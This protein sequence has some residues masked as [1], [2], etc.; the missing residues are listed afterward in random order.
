MKIRTKLYLSLSLTIILFGIIFVVYGFIQRESFVGLFINEAHEKEVI[1]DKIL[2]LKGAPLETFTFDYSYW[3]EMVNFIANENESWAKEMINTSVLT[4]YGINAIW[5]YKTDY[6]L[7]YS[8]DNLKDNGFKEVPLNKEIINSVFLHKQLCHFFLNTSKGLMEIRGATIHPTLDVERKTPSR[9]YIFAA[10]LWGKEY[11]D[12]LSRLIGGTIQIT[13]PEEKTV[14]SNQSLEKA[15]I[16]FSRILTDWN[17]TPLI[18][19][20]IRFES[21]G[22]KEFNHIFKQRFIIF[23]LFAGSILVIILFIFTRWISMPL[24]KISFALN[25]KDPSY[26]ASLKRHNDEF[27]DILLMIENFLKQEEILRKSEEQFRLVVEE[28]VDYAIFMLDS[29]GRIVS[30]NKGAERIKGYR[31]GEIIGKHFSAFYTSE[32]IQRGKPE[33]ELKKARVEGRCEDEGW[34]VRK[35]G[36]QFLANAIITALY[37]QAGNLRG[38]SKVTRDIT[39]RKKS[40]DELYR[41][42]R[43]LKTISECNQTL[44]RATN[45]SNLLHEIC[46]NL[47]GVGGYRL[48]WVGF[49]EQNEKKIVRPVAQAGYE[50]GY[51]EN[52]NF[53]WSDAE[54]GHGPTGTSIRMG[55]ICICKNVLTDPRFAPW[56]DEAIKRG[57]ASSIAL[58]MTAE[59][60]T[61]G[62]LNIYADELDA[63]DEQ[64]VSMLEELTND[65]AYGIFALRTHSEREQ[66]QESL[67]KLH[68]AIEQTA[69]IVV[70]T[71]KEGVIEYVNPAFEKTTG[72]AKEI[73]IGQTP[74]II[75]SGK[76]DQRFYEMLWKTILSGN[77]FRDTLIN[78]RKN[79]EFY[80]A[81][82]AITPIIDKEGNITHFVSTDKDITERKEIE[83]T[84]RLAQL[85]EL[86][87]DMAH[88]VNN[89]LMII[90]GNAQLSLLDGTLN[91]EIK[92]N[93]KI[94][95]EEC[96]RAKDIIQRLL[97]FSRPSKGERK[98]TD[99][100]Q[101]I[102]SVTKL[103]EHQFSLS[104]VKIKKDLKYDLPA[105]VIDEKQ[106]QEV[107]MNLLNNARD[108][109]PEGGEIIINTS[110]DGE[111]CKIEMKDSG[112]G[113][114]DKTLARVFEPFFTT[115]EKGTGLGLS[116]CFGIIKAHNGKIEF[117]SQLQKGTTA[118]IWL[119]IKAEGV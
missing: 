4:N 1:F 3:D 66:A 52:L 38:F 45:E 104:N 112:V 90:S 46:R 116:V 106:M 53:T 61:F 70:I 119:P 114:D 16:T 108:A 18:R 35:D 59:G 2:I 13:N 8:I 48:A 7:L 110:L 101:S 25:S 79:G 14:V 47:V 36:S 26:I 75:K 111:Y 92:S 10:K 24:R 28:T 93:L 33:E 87:A 63:F 77:V 58:P 29:D 68:S 27:G 71:N 23:I 82:K 49:A 55:K 76:H 37:D 73:A 39:K 41:L 109:M 89:P 44:V 15:I 105:I 60:R 11:I 78:R 117:K 103:I 107:F 74:R 65:L 115:K 12:E 57:Y 50:E 67:K 99:I 31:A 56:R 34:R 81:E 42:N 19:L 95:H 86:V 118:H 5:L 100:N 72:Y 51:L 97:K 54:L 43:A 20:N 91:E 98:G 9:G 94:I 102:E 96:N 80:Y 40:E 84:Q 21:Y 62:A 88:E 30:W 17:E 85:G 69:D 113:M 22:L 83:K 64:E 6:S 32:D